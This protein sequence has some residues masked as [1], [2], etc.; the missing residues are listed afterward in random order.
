MGRIY[1][2]LLE[3]SGV[4]RIRF[5]DLRHTSAS[6]LIRQG[7]P[8]KLVSDRLGHTDVAFTLK[9]YT[10]LYDDQKH[11]AAKPLEALMQKP[12]KQKK[13]ETQGQGT[14]V[15]GE[16]WSAV[17]GMHQELREIRQLLEKLLGG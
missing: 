2:R 16:V 17:Q 5:H 10:H 9:V 3:K 1:R 4:I 13:A 12:V 7:V 15:S 14:A 8:A 11:D 6:L